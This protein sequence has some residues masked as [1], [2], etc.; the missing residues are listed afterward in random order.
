MTKRY[1]ALLRGINVGGNSLIKMA[2]L[3]VCLTNDGLR[4]VKTYI[5]SGNIIFSSTETDQEKLSAKIN[6]AIK[7]EFGLDV[8][9]LVLSEAQYEKI[10]KNI[11]KDFGTK[12]GWR[13]NVWFLLPPYDMSQVMGDIGEFRP[14]IESLTV[15]EGVLYQSVF[16]EKYGRTTTSK[17]ASRPIY[18]KITIRNLNTTRKILGLLKAEN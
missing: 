9:V 3:K 13:Y 6:K 17:L 16:M 4:K 14:D 5:A 2:E 11:P 7:V 12:E 1:I 8:S 15:G 18:K 10:V